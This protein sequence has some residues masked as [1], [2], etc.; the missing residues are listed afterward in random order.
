VPTEIVLAS[1]EY[2]FVRYPAITLEANEIPVCSS[3]NE[4][5]LGWNDSKTY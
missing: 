5:T 2:Y 1:N 4:E 3:W